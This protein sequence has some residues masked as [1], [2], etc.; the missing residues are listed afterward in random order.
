MI[1]PPV[2]DWMVETREALDFRA[3][4]DLAGLESLAKPPA[5]QTPAQ[6]VKPALADKGLPQP[7]VRPGSSPVAGPAVPMRVMAG[8]GPA[9][10]DSPGRLE[11]LVNPLAREPAMTQR[12]LSELTGVL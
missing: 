12:T 6:A 10:E 5:G 4:R 11:V 7:V 1:I 8:A 9:V 3:T 2:P